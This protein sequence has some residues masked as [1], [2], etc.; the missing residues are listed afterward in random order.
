M[1]S[2]RLLLRHQNSTQQT[3]T[4]QT[5]RNHPAKPTTHNT[6]RQQNTPIPQH[7]SHWA[8]AG[9]RSELLFADVDISTI[10]APLKQRTAQK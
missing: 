10:S 8:R 2:H 6:S 1:T 4:N 7:I 9:N 5:E 3:P